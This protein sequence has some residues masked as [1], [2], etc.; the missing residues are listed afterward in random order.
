MKNVVLLTVLLFFSIHI[1][2]FANEDIDDWKF[3][4]EIYYSDHKEYKS[5]FLD[6]EIYRYAKDDLSDLR[7]INN[8]NEFVPY[9]VF[10]K[11]SVKIKQVHFNINLE[12][13]DTVILI[14]NEDNLNIRD[15]KIISQDNFKRKYDTY[16]KNGK[17]EEFYTVDSGMIYRLNLKNHKEEKNNVITDFNLN[18]FSKPNIIKIIIHNKDDKPINIDNI[19]INYYTDKIVFK[20]DDNKK[21]KL[22]FGNKYAKMPSYD[23][24]SYKDYIEKEDQEIC[25]I[26]NLTEQNKNYKEKEYKEINHKLILNIIVILISLILVMIIMRKST[27]EEP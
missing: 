4:K 18:Y 5:I 21:Y 9:Y 2:S 1:L 3:S 20:K 13:N 24:K 10:N 14:N 22:L 15:I 12:N 8:Q 17:Y 26:S 7:I 25:N 11:N 19:H 16:Y 27:P 23:I 6:E